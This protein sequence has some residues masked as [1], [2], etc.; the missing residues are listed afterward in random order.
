MEVLP[1]DRLNDW[2]RDFVSH[3]L[4]TIMKRIIT[5][6]AG[7]LLL[8][9]G[10][11]TAPNTPGPGSS[12]RYVGD[13]ASIAFDE[14]IVSVPMQGAREPYQNLHIGLT[15]IINPRKVSTYNPMQVEWMMRRLEP[16]MSAEVLR[17]LTEVQTVS[18]QKFGPL[19]LEIS[20]R[21]Q[22]VVR[23]TLASWTHASEY[24]V[25]IVVV[26][27]YLTDGSVGRLQPRRWW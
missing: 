25:E 26:S 20:S 7:G 16:R 10:C 11:V 2:Q 22:D 17:L 14:V 13:R 8:L 12:A 9:P 27:I 18:P 19:R 21:A 1:T 23:Q 15:A 4:H 5:W 3:Y 24:E 6:L